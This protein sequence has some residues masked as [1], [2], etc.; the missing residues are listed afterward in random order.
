MRRRLLL[1]PAGTGWVA[2]LGVGAESAGGTTVCCSTAGMGGGGVVSFAPVL[3][4]V[5][6]LVAWTRRDQAEDGVEDGLGSGGVDIVGEL[7]RCRM[8]VCGWN[9]TVWLLWLWLWW[10][11]NERA[12]FG[13]GVLLALDLV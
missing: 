2:W 13:G 7:G 8:H 4:C 5:A 6:R 1:E 11:E 10:S 3:I 9:V 12:R